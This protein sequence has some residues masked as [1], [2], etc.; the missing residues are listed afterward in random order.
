MHSQF[1]SA[2]GVRL[3]VYQA[4]KQMFEIR[5]EALLLRDFRTSDLETFRSIRRDAKFQRFYSEEDSAD[6]KADQLLRIFI[7]Q[8]TEN[9]RSKYQLAITTMSGELRHLRY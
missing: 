9:P 2:T 8:A 4:E 7:D 3:V 1:F 6:R 5:T